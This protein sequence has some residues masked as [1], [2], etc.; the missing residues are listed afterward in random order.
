MPLHSYRCAC[1]EEFETLVRGDDVPVCPKC[2]GT[3]LERLLGTIAPDAKSVAKIR[4]GRAQAAKEGH[5]SN[6]SKAERSKIGR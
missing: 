3:A 6:Y 2:G 5:F 1:G 4:E